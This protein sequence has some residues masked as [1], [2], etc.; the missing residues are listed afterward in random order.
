MER[1]GRLMPCIEEEL[2]KSKKVQLRKDAKKA[3]AYIVL[4]GKQLSKVEGQIA[5]IDCKLKNLKL[6][7]KQALY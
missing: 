2:L 6:Q 1:G 5:D 4:Y 3:T 7:M